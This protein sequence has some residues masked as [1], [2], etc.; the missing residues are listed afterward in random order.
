MPES[1]SIGFSLPGRYAKSLLDFDS[2]NFLKDFGVLL[3]ILK[4]NTDTIFLL[5]AQHLKRLYL[6]DFVDV[7]SN[8]LKLQQE[9]SSFL[10]VLIENNRLSLLEDIARCYKTLWNKKNNICNIDVCSAIKLS[11]QEMV[12]VE[13]SIKKFFSEKLD[14]VYKVDE[15]LLGGIVIQAEGILIDV[16]V[17]NHIKTLDQAIRT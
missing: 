16:S 1:L 14:I 5:K 4:S 10:K 9:F 13:T 6:I 3:T 12:E 11:E 15:S 8:K 2:K 7:I 17:K